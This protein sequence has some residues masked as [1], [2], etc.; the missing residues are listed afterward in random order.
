[1]R[2]N[3]IMNSSVSY[4]GIWSPEWQYY[5]Y[6]YDF[7]PESWDGSIIF[8]GANF[9]IY[10]CLA[11]DGDDGFTVY[12]L[13]EPN[14][15]PN[16]Y[17]RDCT[18][19]N[20]YSAFNGWDG[21]V[22]FSIICPGLYNN[23]QNKNFPELPFTDPV[24]EVNDPF[25][26]DPNDYRIFLDPN[27]LFVDQ[28][29][30][31]APFP[32]WTTSI[33]GKPDESMGDIWPH[34]QTRRVDKWPTADLDDDGIVDE[35]DLAEFADWWLIADPDSVDLNSD[36][37]VNFLD[38]AVFAN[39]WLL[40][41]MSI[42]LV[43]P[44]TYQTVDLNNVSGYV[45]IRL[46]DIPLY[47]K[48]V[49]LYVDNV[50]IGDWMLGWNDELQWIGFESDMFSNGWHTIRLVST[51]LTGGV[52]NHK[53]IN[54]YLNNML[55]KVSA[56]D[57]F[58]PDDDYEYSGFYDGDNTLNAEV[59][60]QN[61]QVIWSDTY[62]GRHIN[63]VIP[64]ANFGSEQFCELTITETGSAGAGGAGAAEWFWRYKE[65]LDK[66]VQASRLP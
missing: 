32:G 52:T 31:L 59:T 2:A 39:Q 36:G 42:E 5:G 14:E 20:C 64:G 41:E 38:Y 10:N 33:D 57:Q 22:A 11:D 7:I 62:S 63:I 9:E 46:K 60:D 47:G 55:Y 13:Y 49:S 65:R 30:G 17:S 27:S 53:P 43:N 18:A 26:I 66:E 61:S 51:S 1:M 48:I 44:D 40:N 28:G 21:N 8:E 16:F 37:I 50:Q 24:Y 12:G 58:H 56:S 3:R 29:S 54:V 25:V 45:G 19:T 6:A 15:P 23:V 34:Y 4:Y 35:L